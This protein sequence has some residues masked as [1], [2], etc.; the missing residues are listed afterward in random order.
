MPAV[1]ASADIATTDEETPPRCECIGGCCAA[2]PVVLTVPQ[3]TPIESEM[4]AGRTPFLGP[5]L[6]QL[7]AAHMQQKPPPIPGVQRRELAAAIDWALAKE[8]K[9]RPQRMAEFASALVTQRF[10]PDAEPTMRPTANPLLSGASTVMLDAHKGDAFGT[11]Q[12]MLLDPAVA[13][14]QIPTRPAAPL[15]PRPTPGPRSPGEGTPVMAIVAIVIA[16]LAIGGAI[17]GLTQ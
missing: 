2:S 16:L 10:D 13:R 8:P 5:G 12:T 17:Y 1:N 14:G 11:P 4:L 15:R 9:D 6:G 3:I 7:L